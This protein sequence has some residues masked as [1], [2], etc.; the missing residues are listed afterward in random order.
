M[1]CTVFECYFV[2]FRLYKKTMKNL[3]FIAEQIPIPM[4]I[5]KIN[6]W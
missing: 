1:I 5:I 4:D 2:D 3:K 6:F